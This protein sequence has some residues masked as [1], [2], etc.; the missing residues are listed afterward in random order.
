M[1]YVEPQACTVIADGEK[2]DDWREADGD[3]EILTTVGE[4][5]FLIRLA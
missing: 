4:H 5:T 3:I 1:T 2:S